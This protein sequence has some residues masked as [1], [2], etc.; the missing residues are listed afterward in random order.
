VQHF[1]ASDGLQLAYAIDDSPTL[2][3]RPRLCSFFMPRWAIGYRVSRVII[4]WSAWTCA[5]TARREC[6]RPT[7]RSPCSGWGSVIWRNEPNSL[8]GAIAETCLPNTKRW[9][10]RQQ[11]LQA[12]FSGVSGPRPACRSRLRIAGASDRSYP[13]FG[14]LVPASRWAASRCARLL[15]RYAP[16]TRAGP[17]PAHHA[18]DCSRSHGRPSPLCRSRLCR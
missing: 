11:V 17:V 7:R 6:H 13:A 15:P 4:A 5:A 1:A 12:R 14:F 8:Y 10:R 9:S 18:E 16:R 2:G 3:R